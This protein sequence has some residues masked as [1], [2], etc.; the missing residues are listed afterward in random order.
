MPPLVT[1]AM[2]SA[3]PARFSAWTLFITMLCGSMMSQTGWVS[4]S[5]PNGFRHMYASQLT[6]S[7]P[8]TASHG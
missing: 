7:P 5:P 4:G 6:A 1:F 8:E 2:M 3:C